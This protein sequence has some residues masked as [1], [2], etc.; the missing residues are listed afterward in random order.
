MEAVVWVAL[1]VLIVSV[2]LMV[3]ERID[4]RRQR[5]DNS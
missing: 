4:R 2:V 5:R 3:A 1:G